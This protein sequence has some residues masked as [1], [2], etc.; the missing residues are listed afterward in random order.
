MVT[1]LDLGRLFPGGPLE[2]VGSTCK[3]IAWTFVV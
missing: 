1:F 2:K 3:K